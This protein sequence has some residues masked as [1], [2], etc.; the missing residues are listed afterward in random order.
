MA[1]NTVNV[2]LTL[3]G[4]ILKRLDEKAQN[5]ERPRSFVVRKILERSFGDSQ[6]P[7]LKPK[8]QKEPTTDGR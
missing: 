7:A 2:C 6:R 1:R 8:H 4:S 5:D 3:P